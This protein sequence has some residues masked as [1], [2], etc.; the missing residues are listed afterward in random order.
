MS[1]LVAAMGLAWAFFELGRTFQLRKGSRP[2]KGGA[3][4]GV[5]EKA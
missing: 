5:S 2:P 1:E 4:P 3:E